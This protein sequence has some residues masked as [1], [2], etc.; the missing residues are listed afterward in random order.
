MFRKYFVFAL[1]FCSILSITSYSQKKSDEDKPV[2]I[3]ANVMVLDSKDQL[4]SGIKPE[5]LKIYEDGVEQQITYFAEKRPILNLGIVVDNSGSMRPSLNEMTWASSFVA[6]NLRSDDSAFAVRFVSSDKIEVIQDWTPNRAL[7]IEAFNNMFVEGGQSAVLDAVYL[8]AQKLL[9]RAEKDKTERYALL[10][11]SDVEE[12]D[13]YYK[14]D[15]TIKLFNNTDSQLFILSYAENAPSKKKY[16]RKLSHLLSLETGGTIYTLDK[17]HTRDELK[18]I[19]GKIIIELRSNYVIGYKPTNQ[20]RDDLP[21]KLTVQIA[22]NADGKKQTVL[23][24]ESYI[25]PKSKK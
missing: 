1:L 19:V 7:L 2:Y 9:E 5:D 14:F 11:I 20:N 21:R 17:K 24:R 12:R 16:A 23:I 3:K 8:S 18:N 25:V 4:V 6:N 10:L 22:D 15:E 13:S